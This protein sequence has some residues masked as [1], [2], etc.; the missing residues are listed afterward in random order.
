M[1]PPKLIKFLGLSC[2]STAK[3]CLTLCDPMDRSTPG[4][5]VFYYL[6]KFPQIHAH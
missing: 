2:C 4:F 5:S 6:Q 3:L 1:I